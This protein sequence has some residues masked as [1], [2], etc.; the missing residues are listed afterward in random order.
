LQVDLLKIVLAIAK[1]GCQAEG[2]DRWVCCAVRDVL[3]TATSA[4][5]R[6]NL[7]AKRYGLF[8]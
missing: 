3:S 8:S 5:M 7:F 6:R 2:A 4:P 1:P